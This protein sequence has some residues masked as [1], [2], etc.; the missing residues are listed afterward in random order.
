[1]LKKSFGEIA[2]SSL[3]WEPKD[4]EPLSSLA[5]I[6]PI[7][8]REEHLKYLLHYLVST[9]IAQQHR[10]AIFVVEQ[11]STDPQGF[12]NRAKLFNVG[13]T[14]AKKLFEF[15]SGV[16]KINHHDGLYN[17]RT[18]VVPLYHN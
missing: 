7:R 11:I 5:I 9:L 10:F 6:I 16:L 17:N 18:T 8:G 1:M 2:E 4:C 12:F 3:I 15:T 13:F 14:E